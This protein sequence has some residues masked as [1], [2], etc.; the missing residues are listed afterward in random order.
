MVDTNWKSIETAPRD[1]T[2]ILVGISQNGF[3]QQAVRV[4]WVKW[5]LTKDYF[6]WSGPNG[7]VV[8]GNVWRDDICIEI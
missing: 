3:L 6:A 2:Y 7:G 5:P 8:V 1:G 4:R